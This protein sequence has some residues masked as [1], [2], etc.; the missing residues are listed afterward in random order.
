MPLELSK[1]YLGQLKNITA[2]QL[3]KA[4]KKDGWILDQECRDKRAYIKDTGSSL[5]RIT[6]HYHPQ[7]T[8]SPGL[9]KD[10]LED[11]GW[12]IED[13]RRLKLIQ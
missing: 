5:N 3:V 1:T 8:Y 7:K 12:T 4:L 10:L 6:I 13:L 9:L 11:I 2:D